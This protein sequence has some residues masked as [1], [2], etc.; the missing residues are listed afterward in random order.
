[1]IRLSVSGGRSASNGGVLEDPRSV[2]GDGKLKEAM[3][4]IVDSRSDCG[5]K[6]DEMFEHHLEEADGG[7]DKELASGSEFSYR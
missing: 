2:C 4:L 7:V 6:A 3:R 1:M 5:P